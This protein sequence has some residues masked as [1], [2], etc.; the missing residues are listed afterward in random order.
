[1]LRTSFLAAL[2]LLAAA[3]SLPSATEPVPPAAATA[4]AYP[5]IDPLRW[6]YNLPDWRD[7]GPQ[8][9]LRFSHRLSTSSLGTND[10]ADVQAF[11]AAIAAARPGDPLSFTLAREAGTLACSGRADADGTAAGTC[12]FDPAAGFATALARHGLAP[13][14]SDEMLA[15]T[16]VG[17]KLAT[18]DGLEGKGFQFSDAGD[19]IAVSALGVSAAYADELRDA[20]LQ[21]DQLGDL[22][23]ARALRIDAQWLAQMARADYP[24]LAVGKAIQM[25]ALGVTPD[26]AAR[27][28]R[29]LAATGGLE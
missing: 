19:L 7:A 17:A 28:S 2:A 8:K 23:A 11:V 3:P 9:M 22:I 27:M 12:R 15:L 18:L 5:A 26:Y 29:V 25:R 1:M 21:V 14:D 4:R 24:N 16:L 6:T 20:G 10:S 13:Q